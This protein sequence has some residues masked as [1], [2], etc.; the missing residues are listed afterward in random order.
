MQADGEAVLLFWFVLG[1]FNYIK[2]GE[3][4]FGK[5]EVRVS[6]SSAWDVAAGACLCF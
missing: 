1:V 2:G 3:Y 4:C 5:Q 6:Y